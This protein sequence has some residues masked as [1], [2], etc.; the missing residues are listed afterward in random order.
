MYKVVLVYCSWFFFFP[1]IE[2]HYINQANLE[3][4]ELYLSAFPVLGFQACTTMLD[5]FYISV[6]D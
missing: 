6:E 5:F 4:A 2:T 1:E 3:F